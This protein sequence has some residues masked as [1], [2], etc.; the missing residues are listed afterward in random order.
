MIVI[1]GADVIE[2]LTHSNNGIIYQNSD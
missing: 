1:P 2:S